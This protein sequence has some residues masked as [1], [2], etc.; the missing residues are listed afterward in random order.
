MQ[1]IQGKS[2]QPG[3][4]V[5][6]IRLYDRGGS[7]PTKLSS[8]TPQRERDRF[9]AAK[10]QA[11]LELRQLQEHACSRLGGDLAAIIQVQSAMLEDP[12]FL[13]GV[14]ERIRQGASAEFAAL[15]SGEDCADMLLA[16]QDEYLRSRAAD[17]R[18]LARRLAGILSGQEG[19]PQPPAGILVVQDLSPSEAVGLDSSTLLGLVS[20]QGSSNSHT[21]ILARAMGIPSL[22]GVEIDPA[23]DGLPAVLDGDQGILYLEPDDEIRSAALERQRVLLEQQQ[24]LLAQCGGPCLTKD[25]R[26]VELYAN[27]GSPREAWTARANGAQ[28]IGLF[29]SEYLYLGRRTCPTEEEQ[30]EAYRQTVLAMDGMKVII[31]TLDVGADKQAPCLAQES[32]LNPALG[33][34]GIRY[35]LTHPELFCQQLR[36]ILRAAAFGPIGVMFPMVTSAQEVRAAKEMLEDCRRDLLSKG[37]EPGPVEIGTMIETPAAVVLA[38]QLAQ[39]VDFFSIGTN[40]LSQYTLAADRQNPRLAALCDADYTALMRMIRHT[41]DTAHR[42]G[43][44]VGLCG[45]MGADPAMTG[46]LL[47]LGLDEL[48]VS[49]P[50][51][52]STR[53]CISG[54]PLAQPSG[55]H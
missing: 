5:G 14:E 52:L 7:S 11:A 1:T 49:P 36:A 18:D 19:A 15:A 4:A 28:G 34:R 38:D 2:I 13:E 9:L 16:T 17:A 31:R 47:R 46:A 10:A 40:D 43:C 6:P 55:V 39:E 29:R 25:G 41:V 42:F 3:I 50:A 54:I 24:R 21:A 33:Y 51:L 20:C 53:E 8:L 35:S 32:E 30:F 27:V 44:R 23:W 48:S 45:E 22:I 12:D 37:I 26:K